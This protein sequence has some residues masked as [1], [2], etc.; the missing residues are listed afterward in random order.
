MAD[1]GSIV[2]QAQATGAMVAIGADA[3][4]LVA[5][6]DKMTH[7]IEVGGTDPAAWTVAIDF[8]EAVN[9]WNYARA[10]ARGCVYLAPGGVAP[11]EEG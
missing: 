8:H 1:S 10:S 11:M 3:V 5:G 4:Y 7:V 2:F 9:L 6:R